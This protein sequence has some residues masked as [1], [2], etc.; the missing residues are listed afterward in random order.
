MKAGFIG[1]GKMGN[2][3]CGNLISKGHEVAV[4]DL[5]PK[6]MS[7]FEGRAVLASGPETLFDRSEVVFLSLPGSADVEAMTD[8]FL[9]LGVKGKAVIDLSTSY[10]SSSKIIQAKFKEAGGVFLDAPLTG[11]PTGAA[12]GFW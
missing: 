6:A 4:Y 10:P 1:L 5:S 11:T 3:C 9:A 7:A 2:G 8:R 12:E